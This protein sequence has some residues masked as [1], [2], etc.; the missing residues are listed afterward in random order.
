MMRLTKD[1]E[2]IRTPLHFVGRIMF[3]LVLA[4]VLGV[5]GIG[6]AW[7]MFVFWGATSHNT[8]L[9]LFFSGAGIG[10]SSGTFLAWFRVDRLPSVPVIILWWLFLAVVGATGALL[11]YQFG[12]RQ[13]VEC[14]VGPPLNPIAYMTLGTA[15]S[16]NLVALVY[17]IVRQ[18]KML[19]LDKSH[20]RGT[21]SFVL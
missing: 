13:A 7:S 3:G 9:L 17:G 21:S 5:V 4:T 8:L 19:R 18:T 11:G 12:S 14:C 10:A 16:T 2:K 15:I 20:N 1:M 6:I